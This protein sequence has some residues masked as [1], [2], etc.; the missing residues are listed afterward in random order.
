LL[1]TLT[2]AALLE[3]NR[4]EIVKNITEMARLRKSL[5]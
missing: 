3:N 2:L 4:E 5:G 1:S